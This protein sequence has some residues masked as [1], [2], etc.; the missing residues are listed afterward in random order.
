MLFSYSVL[1]WNHNELVCDGIP[2]GVN[3]T[4]FLTQQ[5]FDYINE[6]NDRLWLLVTWIIS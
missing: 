1:A 6:I 3:L 2:I 4:I 5:T